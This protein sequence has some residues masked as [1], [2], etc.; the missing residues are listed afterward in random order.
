MRSVRSLLSTLVYAITT[1]P[2]LMHH[3]GRLWKSRTSIDEVYCEGARYVLVGV[4]S[5]QVAV[6]TLDGAGQLGGGGQGAE[7][8][9]GQLQ[10]KAGRLS[11]TGC[12]IL[13]L[14][15]RF[16]LVLLFPTLFP[17]M[18]SGKG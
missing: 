14:L 17:H 18:C 7:A 9:P 10:R 2:R 4:D 11:S 8:A 15:L 5:T 1:T 3:T 6:M 16:P 13:A 12:A